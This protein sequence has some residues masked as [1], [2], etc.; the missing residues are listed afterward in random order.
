M[1]V[2]DSQRALQEFK[3]ALKLNPRQPRAA[4]GAGDAAYQLADYPQARSFLQKAVEANPRNLQAA[5]KLEI[6]KLVLELDPFARRLSQKERNKRTIAAFQQAL[7]H[8]KQCAQ[9]RGIRLQS[10]QAAEPFATVYSKAA[11]MHAKV[12]NNSLRRNPDLITSVMD[13]VMQM[14]ETAQQAC[15]TPPAPDQALLKISHMRGGTER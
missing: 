5:E 4:A 15:G 13:L 9:S 7:S 11:K 12:N 6:S 10:Q 2:G 14:E 1:E 3:R 8:M